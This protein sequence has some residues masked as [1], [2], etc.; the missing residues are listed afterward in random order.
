M[1]D[2]KRDATFHPGTEPWR[3]QLPERTA[4]ETFAQHGAPPVNPGRTDDRMAYASPGVPPWGS[5]SQDIGH[6]APRRGGWRAWN[7]IVWVLIGV[8]A[9]VLCGVGALALAG[10]GGKAV[11]DSVD[12]QTNQQA[13]DRKA[14]VK[15]TSCSRGEFGLVTVRFTVHNSSD[16][17][18]SYLPQFNIEDSKGTVYGQATGVVNDLAPG[19]DY[20][21][22]A[23]GVDEVPAGTKVTCTL[24]NA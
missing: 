23:M 24:S 12:Q 13:T 3:G 17:A 9:L 14:D 20:K 5:L 19:K 18:Q 22:S 10:A 1:T 21:G 7:P 8:A 11:V 16:Q 15:V 4:F 2:E 6:P